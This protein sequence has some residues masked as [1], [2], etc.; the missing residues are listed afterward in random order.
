M[1]GAAVATA[2][3]ERRQPGEGA[4][5][6]AL[7]WLR[8]RLDGVP[9]DLAGAV[10]DIVRAVDVPG[11]TPVPDLLAAAA[12][13]ELDRVVERPAGREVAVRLLAADAVLTYAFQ[14][15]A[16]LDADVPALAEEV[17]LRG[18]IGARLAEL[19]GEVAT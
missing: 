6:R 14:A 5:R 12:V 4:R 7:E 15:A 17:G 2:G 1:S 8:P 19:T 9:E 16:E 10:G 11:D 13:E 18:R 3:E